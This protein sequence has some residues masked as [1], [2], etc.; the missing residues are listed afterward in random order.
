MDKYHFED[1]IDPKDQQK[2]KSEEPVYRGGTLDALS[3]M[4]RM[5]QVGLSADQA[6]ALIEEEEAE[7]SRV[8]YI[9]EGICDET[10]RK[11]DSYLR[12]CIPSDLER[13]NSIL[14]EPMAEGLKKGELAEEYY[15]IKP[16]QL[17]ML[18]RPGYKNR[19]NRNLVLC[20][21][22]MSRELVC[23]DD[24][25]HIL[26]ELGQ[27]GLYDK[28]GNYRENMRNWMLMNIFDYAQEYECPRDRWLFFANDILRSMDM[29]PLYRVENPRR[30]T[31]SR[32][33]QELFD[34][35]KSSA[36]AV[37]RTE[38]YMKFRRECFERY[39][40][41]LGESIT[42]AQYR[43]AR[44]ASIGV[45]SVKNILCASQMSSKTR[46]SRPTLILMA[47]EMGCN[48]D[49]CNRILMETGFTLLYPFRE[50]NEDRTYIYQLLQ[51]SLSRKG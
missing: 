6:M 17:S 45:D 33:E 19:V 41:R 27:P 46:S 40:S 12:Y 47:I 49:E 26:M 39:R 3:A 20:A 4:L 35:W 23:L 42:E 22:L 24:A 13:S 34:R 18:I 44:E 31:F 51:N 7:Q 16:A 8:L 11:K 5:A 36:Q 25:N 10:D 9:P 48:L 2:P 30:I 28:T 1:M 38:G 32:Q 21:L 14:L 15:H 29:E 37:P 50:S 43:M